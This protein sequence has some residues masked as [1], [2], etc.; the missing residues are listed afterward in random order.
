[1]RLSKNNFNIEI[2]LDT[3]KNKIQVKTKHFNEKVRKAN[4]KNLLRRS[5]DRKLSK[6]RNNI[7]KRNLSGVSF[8][9]KIKR[10]LRKLQKTNKKTKCESDKDEY[11]P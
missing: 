2:D 5:C 1:M 6:D 11:N 10:R 8:K 9:N 7:A 4:M 3:N